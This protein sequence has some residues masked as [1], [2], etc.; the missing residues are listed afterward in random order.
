VTDRDTGRSPLPLDEAAAYLGLPAEAVEALVAGQ[1]LPT[2]GP[3]GLEFRLVDLKAFLA[4]N[5]DYGSGNLLHLEA[6][7]PDPQALL[8]DLDTR[9]DEMANRA[10]ENLEGADTTVVMLS[11]P[12]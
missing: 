3:N 1:F 8:E 9:S 5:A 6:D 7:D 10:F 4:R 12:R 2:A 11:P